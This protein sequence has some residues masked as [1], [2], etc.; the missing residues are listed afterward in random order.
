MSR[1][2]EI[3]WDRIRDVL[4]CHPGGLPTPEIAALAAPVPGKGNAALLCHMMLRRHEG[5]GH[6]RR[7]G[8]VALGGQTVIWQLPPRRGELAQRLAR[9]VRA[10]SLESRKLGLLRRRLA[11]LARIEEALEELERVECELEALDDDGL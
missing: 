1:P 7:A 9:E 3:P 11:A 2:P 10:Y 8:R 5:L 4:S 6:V